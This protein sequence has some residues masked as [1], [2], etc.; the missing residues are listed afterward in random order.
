[1]TN[2]LATAITGDMGVSKW[3]CCSRKGG[4]A[5]TNRVCARISI[6]LLVAVA[7]LVAAPTISFG[8]NSNLVLPPS[9]NVVGGKTYADW[10]V[11]WWQFFL[12]LSKEDFNA[13]TI[14]QENPN[15]AFL[16]GGPSI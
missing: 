8:S 6:C 15:V 1:M 7:V 3:K 10:S 4:P 14:G 11:L 13:C 16:Y 5:M 9:S 2:R 12:P